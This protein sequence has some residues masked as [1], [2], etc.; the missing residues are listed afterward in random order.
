MHNMMSNSAPRVPK[1]PYCNMLTCLQT[2]IVIAFY[3]KE[4]NRLICTYY[5]GVKQTVMVM[6]GKTPEKQTIT[7]SDTYVLMLSMVTIIFISC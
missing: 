4:E 3:A 6:A 2:K 5:S 7:L 1:D